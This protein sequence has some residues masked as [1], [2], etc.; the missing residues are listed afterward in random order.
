[1]T[2]LSFSL[3]LIIIYF[4]FDHSISMETRMKN[5]KLLIINGIA[6]ITVTS[7]NKNILG[8]LPVIFQYIVIIILCAI[9]LGTIIEQMKN[10]FHVK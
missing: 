10:Y 9:A 1:M 5:F 4:S 3:L 2:G 7:L 6:S 8:S